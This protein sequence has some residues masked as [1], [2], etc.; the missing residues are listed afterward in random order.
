MG[1]ILGKCLAPARGCFTEPGDELRG[2]GLGGL[3]EIV[4]GAHVLACIDQGAPWQW[5]HVRIEPQIVGEN[6]VGAMLQHQGNLSDT[7]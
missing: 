6:I 7:L 4:S 1:I 2:K 3:P 5:T